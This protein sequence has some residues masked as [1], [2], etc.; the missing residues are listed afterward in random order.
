M[1]CKTVFKAIA[2]P[3]EEADTAAVEPSPKKQKKA[4]D[5][6]D[7]DGKKGLTDVLTAAFKKKEELRGLCDELEVAYLKKDPVPELVEKLVKEMRKGFKPA[8]ETLKIPTL[9]SMLAAQSLKVSGKKEELVDRVI[10][11]LA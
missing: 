11:A 3:Q 4:A 8:L 7:G 1:E 6:G 2:E 9:K 10:E 5:K